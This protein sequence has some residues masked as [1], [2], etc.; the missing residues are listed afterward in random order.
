MGGTLQVNKFHSF[1]RNH[2]NSEIYICVKFSSPVIADLY[3]GDPLMSCGHHDVS[4]GNQLT[5]F[6]YYSVAVVILVCEEQTRLNT[7]IDV[8]LAEAQVDLS[9]TETPLALKCTHRH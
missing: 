3:R 1:G 2:E 4:P 5:S 7:S 9:S 6:S 8:A